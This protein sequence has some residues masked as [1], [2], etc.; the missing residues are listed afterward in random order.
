MSASIETSAVFLKDEMS[1]I[2]SKITKYAFS[3]GQNTVAEQR[4]LGGNPEVDVSYQWLT[5]FLEDDEELEKIRVAYRKG[6]MLTGELKAK[7]IEEIQKYVKAYQERRALVTDEMVDHL[8]SV[9]PLEWKGN[10]NAKKVGGKTK[11]GEAA[12]G[13]AEGGEKLT[14]NQLKKLEKQK[15]IDTKKAAKAAAPS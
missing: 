4:E 5:F 11:E 15:M 1:R 2:K 8:M 7:C 9:R 12:E 10:L 13:T 3:G 6:D 14:K